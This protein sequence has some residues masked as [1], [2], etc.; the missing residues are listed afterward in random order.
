MSLIE[1]YK[2]TRLITNDVYLAAYLLS[3]GTELDHLE[4][5][6]RN[7]VSFIFSG[8]R[9][10]LLRESYKQGKVLL[11][12]RSFRENLIR[13]RQEMSSLKRRSERP[14]MNL[15]LHCPN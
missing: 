8:E 5:N 11:N 12:I 4:K 1:K 10:H 15:Q 2:I 13:M 6:S 14:C 7:R 3:E 9:V